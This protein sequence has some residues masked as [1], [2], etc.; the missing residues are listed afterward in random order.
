MAIGADMSLPHS[1]P[2][3]LKKPAAAPMRKTPSY[4]Y[5]PPMIADSAVQDAVNNQ[6]ASSAG[7][8]RA[9]YNDRAGIS[10]GRGQERM[11]DMAQATADAKARVG[12][13]QTEMGAASAN[14]AAQNAY[15]TTMRAEQLGNAGLLENLRSAN[16]M[17]GIAK[18]GWQQDLM[19]AIRR[20]RFGLDSI[21]LDKSPL[22][23]SLLRNQ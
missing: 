5:R 15:D 16:A 9:S 1:Q 10:R 14:A 8:D 12:A 18:Q 21:Y 4:G 6:M 13:A 3:P 22:I 19:E 17:Q 20:G 23:D 7:V 11:A 2:S